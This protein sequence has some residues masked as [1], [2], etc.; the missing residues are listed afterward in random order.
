MF[1]QNADTIE[2]DIV[3]KGNASI[4]AKRQKAIDRAEQWLNFK[5]KTTRELVL[6]NTSKTVPAGKWVRG[7]PYSSFNLSKAENGGGK[8]SCFYSI[9]DKFHASYNYSKLVDSDS[10][11]IYQKH[12]GFGNG[13]TK[14]GPAYGAE[15]TQLVTDAWYYADKAIGRRDFDGWYVLPNAPYVKLIEDWTTILPGDAFHNSGHRRLIVEVDNNGTPDN[16]KDDE[17]TVIEQS[18][19]SL[20]STDAEGVYYI[21]TGKFSYSYSDITGDKYKPYRYTKL[22]E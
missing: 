19:S 10:D 12:T 8:T 7:I 11:K 2:F 13:G 9:D 6:W 21:G 20:G 22:D 3:I 14:T 17:Y 18:V 4:N 15:C 1:K 5:W 16:A